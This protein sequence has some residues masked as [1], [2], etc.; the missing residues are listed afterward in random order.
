MAFDCNTS[1][2]FKIHIVEDLVLIFPFG[3]SIGY[4]KQTVS[5]GTFTVVNMSYDTEITDP[6]H[7][8]GFWKQ[9]QIY[10]IMPLNPLKGTY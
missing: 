5:Q 9:V 1:F 6:V 7:Q 4:F 8:K 10:K 2:P 3:N